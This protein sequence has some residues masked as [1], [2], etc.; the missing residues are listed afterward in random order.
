MPDDVDK[1]VYHIQRH[2]QGEGKAIKAALLGE[3]F[4]CHERHIRGLVNSARRRGYP[5]CSCSTGFFWPAKQEDIGLTYDYLVKSFEARRNAAEGFR[6]GAE[7]VFGEGVL[8]T[9]LF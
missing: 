4:A 7:K 5:V 3:T 6:S 8:Q 2:A 9:E 1:L